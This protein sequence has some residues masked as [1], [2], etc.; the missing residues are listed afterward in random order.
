MQRIRIQRELLKTLLQSTQVRLVVFGL[1]ITV[2]VGTAGYMLIE[3]WNII[4]AL[5]MTVITLTTVGFGEIRPLSES[6][7]IFT[8][9]L[10]LAGVGLITYG[11]SSAIEYVATGEVARVIKARRQYER[12]M[13]MRDHFIVIGYGRVGREVATTFAE[14]NVPFVVIDSNPAAIE[15]ATEEGYVCVQGSG[16][17]DEILLEAGIERA[18]GLVA[19]AGNDA[20]NVFAVL[21][22][23]ALNDRL[24]I[25]ARAIDEQSESKIIRAGANR[26]ISPYVL[27][28]RRM[29]NLAM[30]P[31]VVDFLDIT[32]QASGQEQIL[33][34]VVIEE[35]S[36]L[37]NQ[38]IA[39]VDLRR[40]TGANILALYLPDGQWISNP[41]PSMVLMPGTRLILLGNRQQ[42][43]ETEELARAHTSSSLP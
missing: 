40:R 17:D 26:V 31:H 3:G 39:E 11:L 35:N 9:G 2:L 7:R 16:T 10:I 4:D 13:A 21:T 34:E 27:G 20:T 12:L 23:R 28:G 1:G 41:S 5:Y 24:Q 22:A 42:L 14:A 37:T 19:C 6:G 18:R 25:I 29:A 36:A 43:N 15:R 30:R 32:S 38:T 33:E 8:I